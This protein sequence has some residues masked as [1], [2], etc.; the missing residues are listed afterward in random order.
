[1]SS[2]PINIIHTSYHI[3]AITYILNI[4]NAQHYL[5]IAIVI[6]PTDTACDLM[7]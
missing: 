1:M 4:I 2:S 7:C 6:E 3:L 5:K